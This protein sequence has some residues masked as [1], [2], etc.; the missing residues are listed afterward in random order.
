MKINRIKELFYSEILNP[1]KNWRHNSKE[2]AYLKD[3]LDK[4]NL[5]QVLNKTIVVNTNFTSKSQIDTEIFFGYLLSLYGAKVKVLID[6]GVMEHWDHMVYDGIPNLKKIEKYNLN[7]YYYKYRKR[8]NF[9]FALT[10]MSTVKKAFKTYQNENIEYFYYSDILKKEKFN[11]ENLPE[12]KRYAISSTI[13]FF[14]TSLI[15]YKDKVVDYYYRLSLKNAL[16][17]RTL[18]EYVL[19]YI[20][21]DMLV[22]HLCP[23]LF[24][25]TISQPFT[26]SNLRAFLSLSDNLE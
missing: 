17:A 10:Y 18:A 21:P 19:K 8:K 6:D 20:K 5:K 16:I 15:D 2:Y 9:L 23:P 22:I 3:L 12:L 11:Y 13:R 7:P 26:D 1:I 4:V 24:A 14:K 25:C